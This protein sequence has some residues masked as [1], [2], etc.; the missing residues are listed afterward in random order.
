MNKQ[1]ITI[2][3]SKCGSNHYSINQPLSP[4]IEQTCVKAEI[5]PSL[6]L[7]SDESSTKAIGK[8]SAQKKVLKRTAKSNVEKLKKL[9]EDNKLIQP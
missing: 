2:S 3:L 7:E 6:I 1:E 8:I 9:I 5:K 4:Q